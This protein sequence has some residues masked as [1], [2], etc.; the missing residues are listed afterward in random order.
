MVSH[1]HLALVLATLLPIGALACQ[2][3]PERAQHEAAE[4]QREA[5]RKQS[6]AFA[7]YERAA[8]EA[9]DEAADKAG[10][11]MNALADAQLGLDVATEDKLGKTEKRIADLRAKV[12]TSPTLKLRKSEMEKKL[13]DV[14]IK[15]GQARTT[16]SDARTATDASEFAGKK[17]RLQA[18]IAAIDDALEHLEKNG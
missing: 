5:D 4:A 15:L 18:E 13:E 2:K 8:T 14:S 7:A 10:A 9:Q 3:T 6:K 12:S 1:R 17:T 16:L 11:A